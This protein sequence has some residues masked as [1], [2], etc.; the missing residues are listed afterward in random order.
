MFTSHSTLVISILVLLTSCDDFTYRHVGFLLE[1]EPMRA[2]DR[3]AHHHCVP[4]LRIRLA[5]SRCLGRSV[6]LSL[7]S[8]W[9][10]WSVSLSGTRRLSRKS[11][12]APLLVNVEEA[13]AHTK[14]RLRNKNFSARK[15]KIQDGGGGWWREVLV[16]FHLTQW[17]KCPTS[18]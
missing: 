3:P 17:N 6:S 13:S 7:P 1:C 11:E 5:R 18:A 2:G 9:S 8:C 16:T 15:R 4:T 12:K 10:V 14:K